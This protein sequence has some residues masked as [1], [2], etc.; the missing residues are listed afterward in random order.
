VQL[1]TLRHSKQPA[2]PQADANTTE[3]LR[4]LRFKVKTGE[5]GAPLRSR[6]AQFFQNTNE[7]I[8]GEPGVVQE[9]IE[10][11][12]SEGGSKRIFELLQQPLGD[13]EDGRL[14]IIFD[15][16]LLPFLK[17]ITHVNVLSSIV[18]S[19]RVSSIYNFFYYDGIQP[20]RIFTA[21]C[22]HLSSRKSVLGLGNSDLEQQSIDSFKAAVFAISKMTEVC[23]PAQTNPDLVSVV[24]TLAE[25]LDDT[26]S[27][28]FQYALAAARKLL[29]LAEQRLGLGQQLP[30]IT[31]H[32]PRTAGAQAVFEL[33]R[34]MP[35]VLSLEGPR[36]DNDH[37]D[38]RAISILP[39]PQEI[40]SARNEYLPFTDPETWHINGLAGLLDRH[41]RLLRED[42]IGQLRDAA[43]FELE[44]LQNP[45][46]QI[47][48]DRK[49]QGARVHVYHNVT[50]QD[51]AF[52]T[53]SGPEFAL[54]FDQPQNLLHKSVTARRE[55]WLHCKRFEHEALICLLSS[56][57]LVIFLTVSQPF[58]KQKQEHDMHKSYNLTSDEERA[59]I[60]A[61]P[62][63]SSDILT[64][65]EVL[66]RN[67]SQ[68]SLVEFPGIILPTFQPT[69][70]A[71][72]SIS[73]SLDVPFAEI[74][75]P[76]PSS[77]ES[78][79]AFAV[80]RP[81]YTKKAGFRF[82]LSVIT[83]AGS[84][85]LFDP[86]GD[87]TAAIEE[88]V[89]KSTLD[90]GQADAI[91]KS[92]SRALALIQGPPGTGKSYTGIQLIKALLAIR[93]S[94]DLGP[95]LCV[96]YTN[97]ALDQQQERLLD[98]GV[99][100]I[101]RIGGK[102][103]SERLKDVNLR[104]LAKQVELTKTEK[105][106]RWSYQKKV[107]D[108]TKAICDILKA[109]DRLGS[110]DGV[111][112]FLLEFYP[113]VHAQFFRKTDEE[114]FTTVDY[115]R[116][117]IFERWLQGAAA[118]GLVRTRPLEVL[119]DVHV[120]ATSIGER[121]LLWQ[122][123][124]TE[125][126]QDLEDRLQVTIET[127]ETEKKKLSTIRSEIDLRVLRQANI[128]AVTTS[129]LA[130]NL[131]V[132]RRLNVKVVICEEAGEVLE[133]HLLTALLPS[134]EHAILIGDHEQLRPRV[135]NYDLSVDSRNGIQYSL[136]VSLFERLARPTD[137][138]LPR[139][140][141][142]SLDVQR[143]MHPT[144]SQNI[145][146]IYPR[147]HDADSVKDYPMITGMRDRVYWM[148][149]EHPEDDKAGV[150]STSRSNQHEV[151]M[152]AAVARHLIRQGTYRSE[153]IAILTPYLGQL[154]QIQKALSQSFEI[155]LNDRDVDDLEK[156]LGNDTEEPVVVASND[157]NLPTRSTNAARGAL[158]QA[159]RIATVDNFQGEEATIVL[160]S[161]VRS[162]ADNQPGFLRTTNRINVLL[163]RAKHGMYIIGNS[164]TMANVKMWSDVIET[165]RRDGNFGEELALC[166]PR[167]PDT[168]MLARTPE[169]FVRL[170]PEAGCD[171][172][173]TKLLSCGHAC[174][175]KCHSEMLHDA[176]FCQQACTRP[177]PNCTHNCP[178]PCGA[179][180]DEDCQELVQG[181]EVALPCGHHKT[182]LPCYQF[183]DRS[184][185]CCDAFVDRAVPGCGHTVSEPCFVDVDGDA[186]VCHAICGVTLACGHVCKRQCHKCRPRND[187]SVADANHGECTQRCDRSY[188]LC[189]H[190]CTKRCHGDGP[191]P[192]CRSPCDARCSHGACPKKC[193]EP[194]PL[195]AEA[196]CAS[197][198]PHSRCEMPCAAPCDWIPC[199]RRCTKLLAC[200]CQCP[201][202]CGEICPNGKFCQKCASPAVREQQADLVIFEAY[203][204][205]NLD[206]DPC[207]FTACGHI[208]TLSSMDGI[209]DMSKYYTMDDTDVPTALRTTSEPF[210]S[211]ELKACPT[212]RGSLRNIARYGRIVRR[213]MLDASVKKLTV[214]AHQTHHDLSNRLLRY[215]DALMR[216]RD[217]EKM[218]SQDIDLT[219]PVIKQMRNVR[220]LK[221]SS[222]YRQILPLRGEIFG[223]LEK[224]H[225][226]EMPYQRVRDLVE[227][228]R[229]ADMERQLSPFVVNNHVF[230][231]GAHVQASALFLRC[232][233]IIFADVIALHNHASIAIQPGSLAVDF[234]DNMAACELLINAAQR[235][236]NIRQQAEGHVFWAHFAALQCGT[237]NYPAEQNSP[238]RLSS[239]EK[240]NASALEHLEAADDICARFAGPTN[241]LEEEIQD[242]R[243][244]L[245][246]GTSTSEMRMIVTAMAKEFNGTGHWYRCEN[247][248]PFT[249]GEC[250][251]PMERARCPACNAGIGGESHRADEGVTHAGDIEARFGELEV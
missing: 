232:D 25:M 35:G 132:L 241:G 134:V 8:S 225:E 140:D 159:L 205:I 26:S 199:S 31:P 7:L 123:W 98:E 208:F 36:H 51:R 171:L 152:I 111:A 127:Y 147:L 117:A 162:N 169:D 21:I 177:K 183:H 41:F 213:A 198:C 211:D 71:L 222:R 55:W 109:L 84:E 60:I 182:S 99:E 89:T 48:V 174:V 97:H 184:R 72:Q 245:L 23:T 192:L 92:L 226:D 223:F 243:R 144:I 248:H 130:R 67:E 103:K 77:Q 42:T 249:I 5:K 209:M 153:E 1:L 135:Q 175:S 44:R 4:D 233:L 91:I 45:Y 88:L 156:Q 157:A 116:D 19:A 126:R 149:H 216:S 14:A 3:K 138:D 141:L 176:V 33:A 9:V 229:R 129:G 167:H 46:E 53:S 215:Q 187:G 114:G 10:L 119:R 189:M 201:S 11:L 81:A 137:L 57:G 133:S 108:E 200:G 128:I 69:L 203:G 61:K 29:R 28:T 196:I 2:P 66:Y 238:E 142:S 236:N 231:L 178:L 251:M 191:C 158:S 63:N 219:G 166:C 38:I 86:Q 80:E 188:A 164:N 194:C 100:N 234:A 107:H 24:T 202:V 237:F 6:L 124:L 146:G 115:H 181:I 155:L 161:L 16:Q 110:Q 227:T 59:Y 239:H 242:I 160:L 113:D 37:M 34:E 151:D 54:G 197:H 136:D 145:R 228:S 217:Q 206:D 40:Q 240:R 186:Y 193:S 104:E 139:L 74:L 195:C 154:R 173:C 185:I 207:M 221:S 125:M 27:A 101:V 87:L 49:R 22:R 131:D 204:D 83:K 12:A 246:E 82:D 78:N 244:M 13:M 52:T 73:S 58:Y 93:A 70:Q 212:C 68:I 170:A 172:N 30:E 112:A 76:N 50:I 17:T 218:Y 168:A 32:R 179:A 230:Q 210:S 39:T 79:H 247:G 47:A 56:G 190:K 95:I 250:G 20:V 121:W 148:H 235:T 180:C 163:S 214:W 43:K 18:L 220:S 120:N 15:Q 106:D 143:R 62:I 64:L 150:G 102:S 85:M 118:D 96:C 65:S 165:F 105:H 75:A 122:A 94:A 90:H 224:V